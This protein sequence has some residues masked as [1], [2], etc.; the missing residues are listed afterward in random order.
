MNQNEND[1]TVKKKSLTINSIFYLAYNLLNVL[2]PFVTGI[3]ITRVLL[4]DNV[5]LIESA[6]NIVQY[7]VLLAYLG[8]PTYGM[9][10]VA[11]CRNDKETLN[12]LYSELMTINSI[13]TIIFSVLYLT[14]CV[15]VS[16]IRANFSLYLIV[17]IVLICNLFNNSFL[18]EGLEEFKYISIRNFIFKVLSFLLLLLLVKSN[19][20]Y[21][22]YAF[23]GA[24][25]TAGNN[26]I[27]IINSRKYVKFSLKN[28]NMMQHIKPIL[29]L[30]VVTIAIEINSL[31]DVTMLKLFKGN[32]IVAFYTYGSKI[33]KIILQVVN[34]FT[35]VLI[36][37]I[38]FYYKN[39]RFDDFNKLVS[40]TFKIIIILTIPI[41]IGIFFVSDYLIC[42]M[43]TDV[44]YNSANVLKVLSFIIL[45]SPIG[46]LLGSRILLVTGN[47]KK[48]I[49]PVGT[50]A[51]V[52][53]I[54]NYFLIQ[55]YS[56]IGAAIASVASEFVIMSIYVFMG[57]KHYSLVNVFNSIIKVIFAS[58]IMFIY[59]LLISKISLDPLY[60]TLIQVAG[61]IMIYFSILIFTKEEVCFSY[62]KK[63]FTIF[64]KS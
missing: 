56:E 53:I 55:N 5:G 7:F 13:S 4:P 2:F 1:G 26:I 30:V 51:I 31:V 29:F 28:L 10:E 58:T 52:N 3:Y 12:K 35:M 15:S 50:G 61:A 37:R 60:V 39:G 64:R 16:S 9:R 34:T 20:D 41:I 11:K 38:S 40:K 49:I 27:N 32:E 14:I 48:M 18:Y 17:G 47:E 43:Y 45:I 63:C 44:Y 24:F 33:Y 57:R 25:G 19:D 54:L 42:R 59:L 22:W 36:P 6:R 62:I 8:I 23:I 46:Y 21:L